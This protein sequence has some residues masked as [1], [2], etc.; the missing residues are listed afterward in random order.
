[1][2][3]EPSIFRSSFRKFI[4]LAREWGAVI[5]LDEAEIFMEQ[6]QNKMSANNGLASGQ[7]YQRP[8]TCLIYMLKLYSITA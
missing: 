1:M 4:K 6:L 3:V 7:Q 8:E 2:G 5:L